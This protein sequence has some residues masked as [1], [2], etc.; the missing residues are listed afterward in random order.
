MLSTVSSVAFP[1][2][3]KLKNFHSVYIKYVLGGPHASDLVVLMLGL[4]T[5]YH[6]LNHIILYYSVMYLIGQIK[7][8]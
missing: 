4:P 1:H 5:N 6:C 7:S 3:K 8:I 2:C